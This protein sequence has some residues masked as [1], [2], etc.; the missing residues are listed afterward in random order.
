MTDVLSPGG[1]ADPAV[2]GAIGLAGRSAGGVLGSASAVLK[3]L[4]IPNGPAFSP[5]GMT[6]DVAGNPLGRVGRAPLPPGRPPRP[7]GR[8]A[9]PPSLHDGALY[10]IDV[11][12]P[13]FPANEFVPA[14]S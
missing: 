6:T 13:G 2:M 1:T 12:V 3:G 8:V 7:R 9:R 5:D 10:V 4:T 14:V 11:D